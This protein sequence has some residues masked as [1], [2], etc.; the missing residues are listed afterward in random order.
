MFISAVLCTFQE[1]QKSEG[2]KINICFQFKGVFI[3]LKIILPSACQIICN[4]P[5]NSGNVSWFMVFNVTFNNSSAISWLGDFYLYE[6]CF[7][8]KYIVYICILFFLYMSYML[9]IIKIIVSVKM[10]MSVILCS[11]GLLD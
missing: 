10:Q 9:L 5:S 8:Q 3:F 2:E 6:T 1:T 11:H 4:I 7:E